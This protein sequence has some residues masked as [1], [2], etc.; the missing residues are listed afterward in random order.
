[1]LHH[2][3]TVYVVVYTVFSLYFITHSVRAVEQQLLCDGIRF[4]MR[5]YGCACKFEC[6]V[7]RLPFLSICCCRKHT[8]TPN[9]SLTHSHIHIRQLTRI[10]CT[11]FD[12]YEKFAK[13]INSLYFFV[14][15]SVLF[16]SRAQ[17]FIRLPPIKFNFSIALHP[18]LVK[19][20]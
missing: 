20:A 2:E 4:V 9:R 1:M 14:P 6:L 3:R 8:H 11:I 17:T 5:A 16:L 15:F 7:L 13:P 12:F 10:E 18:Q 19:I